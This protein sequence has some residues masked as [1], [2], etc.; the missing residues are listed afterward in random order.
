MYQKQAIA[1]SLEQAATVWGLGGQ[2]AS[3]SG[4]EYSLLFEEIMRS[5]T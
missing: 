1:Y 4:K 3:Y 2:P 5:L